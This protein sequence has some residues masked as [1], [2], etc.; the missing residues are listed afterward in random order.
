MNE[1]LRKLRYG[2]AEKRVLAEVPPRVEYRLT[3]FG[4][5]FATMLE[6]IDWLQRSLDATYGDLA[7]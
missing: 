5:K 6:G 3:R 7:A 1:R 2:I 4:A